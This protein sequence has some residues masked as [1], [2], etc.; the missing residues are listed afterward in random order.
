MDIIEIFRGHYGRIGIFFGVI[1][2]AITLIH[3]SVGSFSSQPPLEEVVAEKALKIQSAVKAAL[4]REKT[5]ISHPKRSFDTDKIVSLSTAMF[6]LTAIVLAVVSYLRREDTR[7][8]VCAAG[9]GSGVIALQYFA[10]AIG[11]IVFAVLIAAVLSKF[12]LD[13]DFG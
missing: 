1:A 5:S 13:F 6:G 11:A 2:L 4:K 10:V 3:F 12:D 8:V 7:A 9:L